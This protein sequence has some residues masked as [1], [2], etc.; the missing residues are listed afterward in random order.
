MVILLNTCIY[1]LLTSSET[2]QCN[3]AH[4]CENH[5]KTCIPSSN[6]CDILC[7]AD[8]A[9]HSAI[10]DCPRQRAKS[11]YILRVEDYMRMGIYEMIPGRLN[12][13]C[14]RIFQRLFDGYAREMESQH[15]FSMKIPLLVIQL[16][17]HYYPW[18]L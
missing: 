3:S 14:K 15:V 9:C 12:N 18:F 11:D 7:T 8:R 6:E 5:K 16:I 1:F 2:I 4:E 17:S 13:E 10:F